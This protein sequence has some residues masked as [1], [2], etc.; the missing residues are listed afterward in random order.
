MIQHDMKPTIESFNFPE[1]KQTAAQ[2][3]KQNKE[4][5]N[6][7]TGGQKLWENCEF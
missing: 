7:W 3:P 4:E 2:K 6:K 1:L 5:E